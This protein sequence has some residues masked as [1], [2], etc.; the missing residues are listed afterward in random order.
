MKFRRGTKGKHKTESNKSIKI[1]LSRYWKCQKWNEVI[2]MK[3]PERRPTVNKRI[4]E[5]ER[6]IPFTFEFRKIRLE[7]TNTII[8]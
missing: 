7:K 1:F 8:D 4:G 6:N 5:V 3:F 2:N